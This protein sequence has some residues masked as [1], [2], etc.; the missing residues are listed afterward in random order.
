MVTNKTAY[1]VRHPIHPDTSNPATRTLLKTTDKYYVYIPFRVNHYIFDMDSVRKECGVFLLKDIKNPLSIAPELTLVKGRS[2]SGFNKLTVTLSKADD[3]D[4]S[5][6]I[7]KRATLIFSKEYY[8]PELA[9]K[10]ASLKKLNFEK[11]TGW[12]IVA[13]TGP[14]ERFKLK[15][16]DPVSDD[17]GKGPA[18]DDKES[19]S[20]K[21]N[22]VDDGL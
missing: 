19:T 10:I 21:K 12:N 3:K 6:N 16:A 5:K 4:K 7:I 17:K 11:D 20:L 15:V 1:Y 8:T 22:M 14:K 18:S 9:T 13:I 2:K